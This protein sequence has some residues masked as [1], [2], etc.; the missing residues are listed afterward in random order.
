MAWCWGSSGSV[1]RLHTRPSTKSLGLRW[2]RSS[3]QRGNSLD[4]SRHAETLRIRQLHG[5]GTADGRYQLFG[6]PTLILKRR[7][8]TGYVVLPSAGYRVLV[9]T[10][11]LVMRWPW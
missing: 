6:Y 3:R 8:D 7:F 5:D 4:Q 1:R 10:T 2:T 9:F 11:G